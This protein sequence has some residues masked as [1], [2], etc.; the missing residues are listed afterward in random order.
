[1]KNTTASPILVLFAI[2]IT[3][4]IL[5]SSEIYGLEA[6]EV[7]SS[8]TR[9]SITKRCGNT[10]CRKDA[11]CINNAHCGTRRCLAFVVK[12]ERTKSCVSIDNTR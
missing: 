10:S 7:Q 5:S 1:M 9:A 3:T 8:I 11:D 4:F 2:L 12:G 6:M